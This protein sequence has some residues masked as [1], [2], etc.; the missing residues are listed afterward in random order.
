MEMLSSSLQKLGVEHEEL[1]KMYEEASLKAGKL[2][3]LEV[4][5]LP[6]NII[7]AWT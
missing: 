7:K 1:K 2:A 3:P 6:S 5:V 4:R